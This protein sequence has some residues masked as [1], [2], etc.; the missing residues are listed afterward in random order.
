[1]SEDR[2]AIGRGERQSGAAERDKNRKTRDANRA[3]ADASK[4]ASDAKKSAAAGKRGARL[5]RA[6]S[7]GRSRKSLR[8]ASTRAGGG[9]GIAIKSN[10][11]GRGFRG[12]ID[13]ATDPSKNPKLVFS[14]CSDDPKAALRTMIRCA[15]LRPEISQPV[16][17]VTLSLPPKNGHGEERW[18]DIVVELREQ[19]GIDDSYPCVAVQHHDTDHDH[20]HLIFSRVSVD[21]RVHDQRNI[22][23]RCS[24]AEPVLEH[25]FNL[26][27]IP[28]DEF[29]TRGHISK[30]EIEM[31]LRTK[32]LPPRL[33][34]AAALA[35]A[36]Q[37]H[38]TI[39]LFVERLNAAGVG[40]EANVS[41]TTGK[42]SGFS[43]SFDGIA[44]GASKIDKKYGWKSLEEM[45]DYDQTR[46][47][48]Y[49]TGLDGSP[50]TAGADAARTSA[51]VAGLIRAVA[52]VSPPTVDATGSAA[53]PA[54]PADRAIRKLDQDPEEGILDTEF[55]TGR[56]DRDVD[57]LP[58]RPGDHLDR[59]AHDADV[60]NLQTSTLTTKARAAEIAR[61]AEITLPGFTGQRQLDLSLHRWVESLPNRITAE[62]R[63]TG[64]RVLL[65]AMLDSRDRTAAIKN[66]SG[67][68][69]TDPKIINDEQLTTLLIDAGSI[70][71]PIKITGTPDFCQRVNALAAA[72]GLVVVHDHQ[73]SDSDRKAAQ[74]RH[75]ERQREA[76]S[77]PAP[78]P[79]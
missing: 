76:L 40:V 34:I 37:G 53:V 42:M 17:H 65:T 39:Q 66:N 70:E 16:G 27:L 23:L 71:Q 75:E 52:A 55:A 21:G 18:K 63:T 45:I 74:R 41:L 68:S 33:Q 4:G 38:P 61:P 9:R 44:F 57:P 14:N 25:K 31:G 49:L 62:H 72:Q 67:Y 56:A 5:A 20:V 13:Y 60:H 35:V 54:A 58:D 46:D 15:E 78:T 24:S 30:N 1:M 28:S 22:G 6:G 8:S 50:G 47:S 48:E 79:K 43:F 32:A 29:K 59:L 10:K 7:A 26:P 3:T 69:I 73:I 2:A 77:A 12:L 19:L 11:N 64:H 51:A 36:A